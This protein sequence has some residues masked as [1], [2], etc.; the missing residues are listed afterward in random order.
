M[1]ASANGYRLPTDAQWEY[2]ARGGGTPSTTTSFADKWAGTDTE[3]ALGNYAW[4]H[5]NSGNATHPVGGKTANVLGLYDMSGNVYEW[6]W[7]WYGTVGTGS[8]TDPQGAVPD[9]SRVI[10][11]GSWHDDASICAVASRLYMY[12]YYWFSNYIGFRVVCP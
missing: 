10:R 7:D 4:Y 9:T 1:D 5:G 2:A 11:G 6:C 12:P 3:S 8:E